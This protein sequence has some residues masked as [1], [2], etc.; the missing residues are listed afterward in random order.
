VPRSELILILSAMAGIVA[1]F[2]ALAR[3]GGW[4]ELARH[5]PGVSAS[6]MR[7]GRWG[8]WEGNRRN[9]WSLTSIRLRWFVGYNGCV[10]WRADDTYL[11]LRIMPPFNIFH[12]PVSIPWSEVEVQHVTRW[13]ARLR[14]S[15]I[16][17]FVSR[18]VAAILIQ[19]AAHGNP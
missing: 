18:R 8:W 11:H 17:L 2:W 5:H 12:P 6:A 16:P 15:G 9:W 4:R 14:V 1:L 10:L 13:Y 19:Q 3:I 7:D